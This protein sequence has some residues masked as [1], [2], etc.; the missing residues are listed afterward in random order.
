[1]RASFPSTEGACTENDMKKILVVGS[2]NVDL[3]VCTPVLPREGQ[4]ILGRSF[5]KFPG[6][7]G[8]NQSVALARLGAH[9]TH[10]GKVGSDDHARLLKKSLGQA[11]VLLDGLMED[12]S[13]QTGVAFIQLADGGANTIVVIPGANMRLL[14]SDLDPFMPLLRQADFIAIQNEIPMETNLKAAR[15]GREGGATVIYNPAPYRQ[16]SDQIYPLADLIVPNEIELSELTGLPVTTDGQIESAAGKLLENGE[17]KAVVVTLGAR[18]CMVKE[19]EKSNLFP[20]VNVK[21]VDTTAAGDAF[22]AG[23]IWSLSEG[24]SLIDSVRL[25][26]QVAAYAVTILG[27]QPSLPTREQFEQFRAQLNE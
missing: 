11:G 12:R 20:A 15:I 18:G 25:A 7:K 14:P 3:V 9:V 17:A 1:M 19:R 23:M 6:G 16:G 21:A 24:K 5:N 8:A 10:I 26:N 13:T 27:A 22:I 2:L 4:T